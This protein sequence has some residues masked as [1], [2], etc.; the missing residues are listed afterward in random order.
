MGFAKLITKTAD[1]TRDRITRLMLLMLVSAN[2]AHATFPGRNGLIAFQ[3]QTDAGVQIFTV[4]SN[5]HDLRQITHIDGDAV[6]PDWSPDGKE[7]V[8]LQA[9]GGKTNLAKV[10]TSGNE[11]PV[12]LRRDVDWS[13]LPD[14][15]PT[16]EWITFEDNDGAELVSPDGKNLKRLG[17]LQTPYLAF[18]KDGKKLYGINMSMDHDELFSLDPT[19][20]KMKV[21]KDIGREWAPRDDLLP[22]VRFSMAPDGKSFVYAVSKIEYDLY[23]L[24]GYRQPGWLGRIGAW[25]K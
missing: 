20:L 19:T 5:G 9:S 8:Y 17:K 4:R 6:V 2:P 10:E 12:V 11:T 16:G 24:Q 23:M 7:Y 1:S 3:A 21:I 13:F 22:G 25:S 14:W 18:S 15:S